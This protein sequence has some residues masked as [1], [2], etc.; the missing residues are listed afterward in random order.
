VTAI[1]WSTGYTEIKDDA[2]PSEHAKGADNDNAWP[3][4]PDAAYHG[5]AGE[6]VA[7]VAPHL[8]KII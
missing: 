7:S 3:T 6:F 1:D 8:N 2:E 4:M 5:L